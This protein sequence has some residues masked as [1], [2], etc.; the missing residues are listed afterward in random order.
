MKNSRIAVLGAG[1]WGTALAFVLAGNTKDAINI[2]ARDGHTVSS[3]NA[4][5][6]NPK[7]FNHS[8][9]PH[10]IVAYNDYKFIEECEIIVLAVPVQSVRSVAKL[11]KP[12]VR[13]NATFVIGSKGIEN[14]SL[15]LVSQILEEEIASCKFV[16]LSGPNFASEIMDGHPSATVIAAKD[17]AVANPVIAAFYNKRFRC[18]FSDDVVGVQ[19][20]GAIKNVLAIATGI[21]LGLGYGENTKALIISRGIAEISRIV[22]A[23]GGKRETVL[24]LAGI[25]DLVLTCGSQASRNMQFGFRLGK[26]NSIN[27]ALGGN[28]VEGYYTTKAIYMLAK[29]KGIYIPIISAVYEILYTEKSVKQVVQHLLDSAPSAA[30]IA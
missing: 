10:N 12:Y 19:I 6:L 24:G 4:H 7:H 21:A 5:H 28:T 26:G 13:N 20:I 25:G 23:L 29:R 30:E 18:Y 22:E 17:L 27:A 11:I 3:I 14:S 8:L 15:E 2:W 16:I 1:S 9:L